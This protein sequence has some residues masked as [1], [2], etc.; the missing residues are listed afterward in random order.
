MRV[1]TIGEVLIDFIAKEE[2]PLNKVTTFEKYPGGAPTNVMVNLSR[3]GVPSGLISKVGND[4]FGKF[5]LEKLKEENVDVSY[6]TLDNVHHTG[7]VF[8]QL[9]G[10]SPE[11]ILYRDVAY[12]YIERK[13]IDL[14]VLDDVMLLHFGSVILVQEPSRSTVLYFVEEAKRRGIPISFDV[15]IRKDL[16]RENIDEMWKNVEKGLSLADVVK[17]SEEETNEILEY[18]GL[19][20]DDFPVLLDE[21]NIKLL[22]ITRG[23]KGCKLL[24]REKSTLKAVGIAPYVVKPVDTTGAGDAFMAAIIAGL[25]AFDKLNTIDGLDIDELEMIGYFANIVAA[26]STL[27]RGAWSAP[28]LKELEKYTEIERIVV[29]LKKKQII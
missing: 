7:I 16:W 23:G 29:K 4:P 8:V 10:A 26:L 13:D 15:N 22:A 21:Y 28:T 17:L 24:L 18:L 27:K 11:F 12:N 2:G 14:K 3:L 9:I 25:Y 19:P 20:K 1:Y 6:V 5:L